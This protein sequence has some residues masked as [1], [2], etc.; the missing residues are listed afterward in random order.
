MAG[1]CS[2][3]ALPVA[4]SFSNARIS[5][6]LRLLLG[7][8]FEHVVVPFDQILEAAATGYRDAKLESKG[9]AGGLG[10]QASGMT[11]SLG[12]GKLWQDADRFVPPHRRAVG[13]VFQEPSLFPHLSVQ[14]NLAYGR[15]RTAAAGD[16]TLTTDFPSLK[17]PS[18][19]TFTPDVAG[20]R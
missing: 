5:S 20:V 7:R 3:S 14:G 11:A 1:R 15:R 2:V 19:T 12:I 17:G 9:I 10:Y 4:T 8:D 16:V 18:T 6:A 13:Y